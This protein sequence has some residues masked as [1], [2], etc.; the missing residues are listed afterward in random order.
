[1]SAS[2]THT[3][4][5]NFL[6]QILPEYLNTFPKPREIYSAAIQLETF[7][8]IG[9]TRRFGLKWLHDPQLLDAQSEVRGGHNDPLLLDRLCSADL[10]GYPGCFGQPGYRI[11]PVDLK[12]Q[13]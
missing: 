11:C 13:G 9:I 5:N 12:I 3:H 4:E 6:W 7:A 8:L 10:V 1:V 2:C